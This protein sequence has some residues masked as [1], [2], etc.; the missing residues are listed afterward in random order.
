[1]SKIKKKKTLEKCILQN[2]FLIFSHSIKELQTDIQ[3][4]SL[5]MHVNF[6][7]W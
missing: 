2:S 7:G 5:P 1:M 6:K 3:G 4:D